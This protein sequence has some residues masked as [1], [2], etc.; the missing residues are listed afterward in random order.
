MSKR[1]YRI[2]RVWIAGLALGCGELPAQTASSEPSS[3]QSQPAYRL[4]TAVRRVYVDVV[5]LDAQ[6]HPVKGLKPD[7]FQVYE[8]GGVQPVRGF[9]VHEMARGDAVKPDLPP[10]LPSNTFANLVRAPEDS[11]VT[12]ILYDMLNT[13]TDAMPYAHEAMVKFIKDQKSSGRI[14]IFVLGSRLRMLQ[15]F[16]DDE[17]RLLAAINSKEARPQQS[18]QTMVDTT[19]SDQTAGI[20]QNLPPKA[21]TLLSEMDSMETAEHMAILRDRLELTVNAF[22]Q[23]ARFVSTLRGRKNLI[24]LSGSF[25]S[26]VLPNGDSTVSGMSGEFGEAYSLAHDVQEEEN[27]LDVSHVV[28]YPVDVRGLQVNPIFSAA[29]KAPPLKPGPPPPDT[30][31]LQQAAEH[32]TMDSVAES[33]GGRAFY[34]T[35]GLKQAM[36]S[37][38]EDGSSYYTLTYEPTNAKDDGTLRHIKVQLRQGGY[39]LEYRRSYIANPAMNAAAAAADAAAK[40]EEDVFLD[41]GMQHGAPI[42]PELFFEVTVFPVGAAMTASTQ[43][44]DAL[45]EFVKT[46]TKRGSNEPLPVEPIEVQHY[47]VSYAVLGRQLELPPAG[48]GKYATNMTFALAAYSPDSLILNGM[49]VSV[50]NQVSEVEVQ[51]IRMEGYHAS[52]VF[53]APVEASALR[54]AAQDGIGRRMGTVEVPLPVA[55][56]KPHATPA[57]AAAQPK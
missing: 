1:V 42:S 12:V 26:G 6:G 36:Q 57:A 30:F 5:A 39:R 27:L 23:I 38:M 8:D 54:L 33:T 37:A 46:K 3:T 55:P 15:G 16:T 52:M 53:A 51:K 19:E 17:T 50:K 11:P 7:D 43:E 31:N 14:A 44:M 48:N 13:P 20:D 4:Q 34:N 35:N 49:K 2:Y 47:A 28:V 9:D 56:M 40:P 45:R 10:E 29:S 41:A 32:S 18:R 22:A 24:W 25:P 21:T